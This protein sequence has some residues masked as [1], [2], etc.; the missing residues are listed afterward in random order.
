MKN[1]IIIYLHRDAY[2]CWNHYIR[3]N[4]RLFS[5]IFIPFWRQ[6]CAWCLIVI[7]YSKR[8]YRYLDV[9]IGVV[10]SARFIHHFSFLFEYFISDIFRSRR[11]ILSLYTR[12]ITL[13]N[14]RIHLYLFK[15]KPVRRERERRRD[16]H[17]IN[18]QNNDDR[19]CIFFII[20]FTGWVA[21]NRE[22]EREACVKSK[23][24]PYFICST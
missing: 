19:H 2:E 3:T 8:V 22:R 20:Q 21:E 18:E 13:H 16:T 9:F 12:D 14:L 1:Y 24:V 15:C 23:W 7:I 17:T 4:R 5:Y 10:N 6:R 11:T